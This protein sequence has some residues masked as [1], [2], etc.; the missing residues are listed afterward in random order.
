MNLEHSAPPG[1]DVAE[2][3]L[4]P[5]GRRQL[6][7]RRAALGSPFDRIAFD[8]VWVRSCP[9]ADP[10]PLGL[11]LLAYELED[12]TVEDEIHPGGAVLS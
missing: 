9:C 2:L 3:V 10:I 11:V 12:R 4:S 8:N 7:D 1:D 6:R 5:A